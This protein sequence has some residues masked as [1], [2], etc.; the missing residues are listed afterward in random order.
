MACASKTDVRIALYI[1]A[2]PLASEFLI[3][4]PI[5]KFYLTHILH[6]WRSPFSPN[7]FGHRS[8]FIERFGSPDTQRF[9]VWG[10][11]RFGLGKIKR[12]DTKFFQY[13]FC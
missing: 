5:I 3:C 12:E 10:G 1:N 9:G 6:G 8:T 4:I 2:T 13:T 7:T 11:L